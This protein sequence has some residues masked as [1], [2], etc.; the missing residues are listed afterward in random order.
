MLNQPLKYQ[1]QKI[2]FTPALKRARKPFVVRNAIT[3]ML[4]LGFC[5]AVYSYSIMAVKQDDLSDV[6]MPSLPPSENLSDDK[7]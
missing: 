2:L 5:G 1:T 4:L 7:K 6:P 3:G